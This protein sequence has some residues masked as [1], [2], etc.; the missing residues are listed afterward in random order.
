M[1]TATPKDILM[2]ARAIADDIAYNAVTNAEENRP[3]VERWMRRSI[4]KALLAERN[5]AKEKEQLQ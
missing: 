2:R 1:M 5:S 3:V 4:A